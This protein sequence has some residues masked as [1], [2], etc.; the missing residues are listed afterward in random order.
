MRLDKDN[1]L[2]EI[3]K[4]NDKEIENYY[5]KLIS[6]NNALSKVE[7]FNGY[8]KLLNLL[9]FKRIDIADE[10]Q[11]LFESRRD[12]YFLMTITVMGIPE[13][14]ENLAKVR[15]L[16]VAIINNNNN[17]TNNNFINNTK[18]SLLLNTNLTSF[19]NKVENIKHTI[20]KLEFNDKNKLNALMN[21][22]VSDFYTIKTFAHNI[23]GNNSNINSKEYFMESTKL[24]NDCKY[25]YTWP[26]KR[27]TLGHLTKLNST[28]LKL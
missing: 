5:K 18:P 26:P 17:N 2:F 13:A 21:L 12:L 1:I 6:N 4:L 22:I 11:L 15:A 27:I 23:I 9:S 16:G 7:L 3:Q 24:V 8:T 25:A 20:E 28:L 10:S 14:I 19:S